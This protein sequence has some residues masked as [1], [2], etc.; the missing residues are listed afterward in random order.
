MFLDLLT[1]FA[2]Q[3]R[4][5][6]PKPSPSYAPTIFEKHP[7]AECLRK[8]D[9]ANAMERLLGAERIEVETVGPPSRRYSR[10]AL[11]QREAEL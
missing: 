7:D 5:V 9:L 4:D 8:R 3:G 6:T 1:K 11:A 10:L 2:A